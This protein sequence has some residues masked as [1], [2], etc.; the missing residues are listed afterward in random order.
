MSGQ[1]ADRLVVALDAPDLEAAQRL[2]GALGN[3]VGTF[4][5]GLELFARCGPAAVEAAAR[6]GAAVF[7]DLKV[8]DIPRTAAAAVKSAAALS[9]R[10]LT[11]HALGG[12]AMIAAAREAAEACGTARPKLLAVTVLTSHGPDELGRIGL[13]GTPEDN[14]L[15]L[16][17]MAVD[18]GADGLVASP[19][20]AAALRRTLGRRPLIVTPGIRP[21]GSAAGDQV[22]TATPG[23]AIRAGADLL[24]VGR[25]IVAAPDPAAAADAIL[26]EIAAA[27]SGD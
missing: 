8:H 19:R 27:L 22:R 10:L 14:V 7:L 25:P 21:S 16:A 2:A 3:K 4:K 5:V 26:A 9:A 11:L 24:V 6:F 15:R 23:D 13:P 1:V 17:R 12:P 18:A 20:E